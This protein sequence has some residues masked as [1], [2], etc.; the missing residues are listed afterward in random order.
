M[1][2]SSS[3][4]REG[5]RD[6]NADLTKNRNRLLGSPGVQVFF[7]NCC[8]SLTIRVIL[9]SQPSSSLR[10][11]WSSFMMKL[12]GLIVTTRGLFGDRKS[13]FSFDALPF[14][15]VVFFPSSSLMGVVLFPS[16]AH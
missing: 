9:R 7:I 8:L 4:P 6:F 3:S 10:Q 11:C 1:A 12:R 16:P 5:A 14:V 15:V 13:T 2:P